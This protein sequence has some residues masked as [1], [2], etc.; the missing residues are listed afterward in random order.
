MPR[1]G[2]L[3]LKGASLS[4]FSLS[5]GATGSHVPYRSLEQVHAA[6][7]P[8]AAWTVSRLPPDSSR[9]NRQ[10]PGFDATIQ[11]SILRQR[12]ASTRLLVPYLTGS[13]L[14]FPLTLTTRALYPSS[15]RWFKACSCKP[16]LRGLP[17]SSVQHHTIYYQCARGTRRFFCFLT[18]YLVI[19]FEGSKR[20]VPLLRLQSG[21]HTDYQ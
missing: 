2:T 10:K 17:S 20:T 13:I 8:D 1:I 4:D 12:F 21:K 6:S 16:T 9:V 14:P 15:L 11:F 3:I 18:L 19:L 5:I 7:I